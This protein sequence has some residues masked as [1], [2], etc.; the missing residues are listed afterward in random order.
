MGEWY[1]ID[2]RSGEIINCI[3][4]AGNSR[5]PTIMLRSFVDHE[6]LY[7]DPSPPRATLERYRYWN[8]RP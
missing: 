2:R 3:S 7:L 5:A 4:V 8:E 6:H 1:V